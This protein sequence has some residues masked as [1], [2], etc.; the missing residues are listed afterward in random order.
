[1]GV[2]KLDIHKKGMLLGDGK[3]S[4][5]SY[6]SLVGNPGATQFGRLCADEFFNS[7]SRYH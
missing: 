5:V 2:E 7:H 6:K 3:W 1:V 4:A